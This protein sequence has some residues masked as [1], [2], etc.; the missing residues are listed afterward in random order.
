MGKKQNPRAPTRITI[1]LGRADYAALGRIARELQAAS[2]ADAVRRLV[3][4]AA[5]NPQL[6]NARTA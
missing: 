6:L 4:Y 2:Q 1:D 5:A 3:R